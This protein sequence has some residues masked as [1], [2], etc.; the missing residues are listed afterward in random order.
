MFEKND[1]CTAHTHGCTPT[2]RT[3]ALD[4]TITADMLEELTSLTSYFV[5]LYKEFHQ[6]PELSMQEEWTVDRIETELKS[7]GIQP[8]RV[9]GTG[10]VAL[11]EN[12]DGPVVAFR[13]D[14]DGLPMQ[15]KT[16]LAYASTATGT[17]PDS[18]TVPVMH[19][20]GH[21]THITSALV[22]TNLLHENR[23]AWSGTV[24]MIFQPGEEIGA[25]AQAMI[26]DGMWEKFP[27]PAVI[28]GQ[29]VWPGA[30][31]EVTISLGTAMSMADSLKVTVH[32]KQAHG[33]QP[34]NAIDPIVLGA[35]MITRL[36]TVVSREVAGSDMVVLTIGRFNGGTKENIIPET[37]EFTI[38]IRTQDES[39]REKV[40]A[41][42]DRILKGEAAA[43]G[44][45]EPT[46]DLM[47]RFPRCDNNRTHA[48]AL[49]QAMRYNLGVDKVNIAG[50]VTGSEDFGLFGDSIG[51]PYVYWFWGA[52]SKEKLADPAGVSG[53]HSPYFATDIPEVCLTTGITAAL[54]AVLSKVGKQS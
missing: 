41:A 15:E 19:G 17:L 4:G 9:G 51:V 45:P 11:L 50:P 47:Y 28:Y 21:D 20:C 42:V 44:A 3:T 22:A 18:G 46:I 8:I 29:H 33:S 16:G 6:H 23:D 48:E 1:L 7:Y 35:H 36:Q 27:R 39:V 32:G 38:N 34:E 26:D 31:D 13:A 14:T 54:T 30:A 49:A 10:T 37:A 5:D 40:L 24:I 52:Y 12:G 2:E 53:N 43:S 25:G